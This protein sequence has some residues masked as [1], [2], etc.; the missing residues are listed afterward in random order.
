[1]RS[2]SYRSR[3]SVRREVFIHYSV[4]SRPAVYRV[5]SPLIQFCEKF[6]DS[7]KCSANQSIIVPYDRWACLHVLIRFTLIYVLCF[8]SI[9]I[10]RRVTLAYLR[11]CCSAHFHFCTQ[12]LHSTSFLVSFLIERCNDSVVWASWVFRVAW[13]EDSDYGSHYQCSPRIHDNV[14]YRVHI[15]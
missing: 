10:V 4:L 5:E 11:D 13:I 3:S 9:A 7:S 1:M 8:P 14:L 2:L 15:H 12:P 6:L